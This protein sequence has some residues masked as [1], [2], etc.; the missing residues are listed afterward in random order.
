MGDSQ[1]TTIRWYD[2]RADTYAEATRSVDMSPVQDRFLTYVRGDGHILDVGCGSGRDARAFIE[3]GYTV[4]AMDASEKMARIAAEWIGQPVRHERIETFE[5]DQPFD[6]IWASASLL[7]LPEHILPDML[8]R[9]AGWM[10]EEGVFYMSFKQ[11]EGERMASG[12]RFTDMTQPK[13]QTLLKDHTPLTIREIW[14]SGDA[15]G[16]SIRWVSAI[17][18]RAHPE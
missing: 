1:D 14:T 8:K 2:A 3:Q 6:G 11:G 17:A 13:L 15:G 12:R 4:T 9:V 7:H 16:R 18:Q 5:P 10:A